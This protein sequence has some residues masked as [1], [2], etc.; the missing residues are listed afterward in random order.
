MYCN[1]FCNGFS[2][3]NV[4]FLG[5][6]CLLAVAFFYIFYE[7]FFNVMLLKSDLLN[8]KSYISSNVTNL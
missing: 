1:C 6:F 3:K 5:D 2:S 4:V 8:I 7:Y